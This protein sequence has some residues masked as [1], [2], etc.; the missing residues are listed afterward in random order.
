MERTPFGGRIFAHALEIKSE[1]FCRGRGGA[2]LYDGTMAQRALWRCP[3]HRKRFVTKNQWHS[4]SVVPLGA[5]FVGRPRARELFEAYR[6]AVESIGPVE[7]VS[8]RTDLTFM[9]RVRFA[10]CQARKDWLQCTLW[11]KRRAAC[12]RFVK[13]EVPGW[14]YIYTSSCGERRTWTTPNRR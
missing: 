10:G 7:V 5:H 3:R 1:M 12:T 11:L 6:R 14:D 8:N 13:E 9:T 4:C 2:P